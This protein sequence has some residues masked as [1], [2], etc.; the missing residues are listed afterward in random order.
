VRHRRSVF[1]NCLLQ[2]MH[3]FTVQKP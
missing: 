3:N 2:K 1:P